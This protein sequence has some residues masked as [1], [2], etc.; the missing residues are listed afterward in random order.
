LIV[1]GTPASGP[2]ERPAAR[3]WSIAVASACAR[4]GLERDHRVDRAVQTLDAVE[5]LFEQFSGG[6]VER[7]ERPDEFEQRRRGLDHRAI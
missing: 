4:V 5:M 6:H 3:A 7:F 1:T 2:T